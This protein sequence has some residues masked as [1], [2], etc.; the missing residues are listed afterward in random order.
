[1]S[2]TLDLAAIKARL[3]A[4]TLG[5][6]VWHDEV[7]TIPYGNASWNNGDQLVPPDHDGSLGVTGLYRVV[8]I[9]EFSDEMHPLLIADAE[10]IPDDPEKPGEIDWSKWRGLIQV[11]NVGDLTFIAE[12]KNDV[13]ALIAEVERLQKQHPLAPSLHLAPSLYLQ[14][15][16][17]YQETGSPHGTTEL[18][19]LLWLLE[20]RIALPVD[21]AL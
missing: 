4:A 19:L 1:M 2:H 12:A 6:W 18:G 5:E 20:G 3:A 7:G 16:Q 11:E 14:L 21:A 13:A 9:D 8:P 10:D 15:L 17:G